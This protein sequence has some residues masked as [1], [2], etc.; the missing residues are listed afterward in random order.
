MSRLEAGNPV[1]DR[2]LSDPAPPRLM[3]DDIAAILTAT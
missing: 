1:H 3:R 2:A